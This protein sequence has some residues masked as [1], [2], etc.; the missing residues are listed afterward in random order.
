MINNA[1]F[2][3]LLY[4]FYTANSIKLYF[5]KVNASRTFSQLAFTLTINLFSKNINIF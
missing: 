3:Y 2:T 4:T 5:F 1:C